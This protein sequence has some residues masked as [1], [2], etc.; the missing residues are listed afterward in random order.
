[1]EAKKEEVT[2]WAAVLIVARRDKMGSRNVDKIS[3]G[4]SEGMG[5]AR[6][7]VS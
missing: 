6:E 7:S 1:M 2:A 5:W 3:T 4:K